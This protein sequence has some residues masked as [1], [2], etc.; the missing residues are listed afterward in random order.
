MLLAI[1]NMFLFTPVSGESVT[2]LSS[3]GWLTKY[4]LYI[5]VGEVQNTDSATACSVRLLATFYD[6]KNTILDSAGLLVQLDALQPG[7]KSPFYL[8]FY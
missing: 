3:S 4:G 2:I 8:S 1:V 6:S 5:L 7:A